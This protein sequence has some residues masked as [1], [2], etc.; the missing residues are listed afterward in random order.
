[1]QAIPYL[2]AA[3][4]DVITVGDV[5]LDAPLAEQGARYQI[6]IVPPVIAFAR[7]KERAVQISRIVVHR[8]AAT[9]SARNRDALVHQPTDIGLGKRILVAP[10]HDARVVDPQHQD[11]VFREIV[12]PVD[13]VL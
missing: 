12:V 9:V 4:Q 13:P 8:S 2:L 10:D 1:M 7:R 5:R 6:Q 11:V 3:Q